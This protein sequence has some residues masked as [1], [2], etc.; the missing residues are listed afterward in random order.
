MAKAQSK[1][2]RVSWRAAEMLEEAIA[3]DNR[4]TYS[5]IVEDAL[6]IRRLV[7]SIGV[8]DRVYVETASGERIQVWF[9]L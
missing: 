6:K 2:V 5:W 7:H 8:G 9:A 4:K 3:D 1:T